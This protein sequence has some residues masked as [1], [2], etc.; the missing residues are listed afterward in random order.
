MEQCNF[1][2][3]FYVSPPA[4]HFLIGARLFEAVIM[5]LNDVWSE[6]AVI[7]FKG[8]SSICLVMVYNNNNNN[9]KR[10]MVRMFV[11]ERNNSKFQ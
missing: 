3:P 9:S 11:N 4:P 5:I 2:N 7:C 10:F 6:A 8:Y 1:D